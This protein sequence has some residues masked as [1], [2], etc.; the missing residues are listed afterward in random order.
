MKLNLGDLRQ[1]GVPE[2]G[3]APILAK[4]GASRRTPKLN[5]SLRVIISAD[6]ALRMLSSDFENIFTVPRMCYFDRYFSNRIAPY[7]PDLLRNIRE[8]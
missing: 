4:I 8:H 1:S 6:C 3:L 5:C 2:T 7:T